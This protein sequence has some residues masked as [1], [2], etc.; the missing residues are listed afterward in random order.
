MLMF[1]SYFAVEK[2]RKVSMDQKDSKVHQLELVM[3]DGQGQAE[4]DMTC[5][6]GTNKLFIKDTTI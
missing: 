4:K 6:Q 1:L 3:Y 2:K 5:G